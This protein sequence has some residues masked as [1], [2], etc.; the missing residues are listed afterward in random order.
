MLLRRIKTMKHDS[1]PTLMKTNSQENG[2]EAVLKSKN[3][4][5]IKN[6][7]NPPMKENAL[8]SERNGKT[9]LFSLIFSSFFNMYEI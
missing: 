5:D 1:D 4:K 3:P 7:K 8:A 9:H 6:M 2:I